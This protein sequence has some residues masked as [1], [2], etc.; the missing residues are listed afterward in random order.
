MMASAVEADLE[1]TGRILLLRRLWDLAVKGEFHRSIPE[2]H[3]Y[4]KL[5]D[6]FH[7]GKI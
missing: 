1:E 4:R 5:L 2:Y 7:H 6:L 3:E